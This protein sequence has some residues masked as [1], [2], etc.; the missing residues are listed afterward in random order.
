MPLLILILSVGGFFFLFVYFIP[1]RLWIAAVASGVHLSPMTL[2]GMRLR[3]VDP[4]VLVPSLIML[5]KAGL[6]VDTNALEAH[7]LAGG[8]VI[9]VVKALISADKP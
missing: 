9:R 3:N 5:H 1:V 8:D 6:S 7:F 4:F 2:F